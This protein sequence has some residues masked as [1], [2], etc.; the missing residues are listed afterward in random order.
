MRTEATYPSSLRCPRARGKSRVCHGVLGFCRVRDILGQLTYRICS[1]DRRGMGDPGPAS[2][3]GSLFFCPELDHSQRVS[4]V[5]VCAREG[6]GGRVGD[7]AKAIKSGKPKPSALTPKSLSSSQERGHGIAG[8]MNVLGL[9][10]EMCCRQ[11][12]RHYVLFIALKMYMS[13]ESVC[14]LVLM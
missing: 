10:W 2:G 5:C 6:W 3:S 11:A 13:S 7:G 8:G 12:S 14:S 1:S 4:E 9:D